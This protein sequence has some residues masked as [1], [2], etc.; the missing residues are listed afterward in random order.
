M[1]KDSGIKSKCVLV[2]GYKEDLIPE[3]DGT[4]SDW[5]Y[6]LKVPIEQYIPETHHYLLRFLEADLKKVNICLDAAVSE[7]NRDKVHEAADLLRKTHPYF[8][9]HEDHVT[10]CISNS[11]ACMVWNDLSIKDPSPVLDMLGVSDMHYHDADIWKG[12]YERGTVDGLWLCQ[13][14]IQRIVSLILK[15]TNPAL[16]KLPY[17]VRVGL[18]AMLNHAVLRDPCSD[19]ACIEE[20]SQFIL[21]VPKSMKYVSARMDFEEGYEEKYYD[22]VDHVV[23]DDSAFP[24]IIKEIAEKAIAADDGTS[25]TAEKEY[26]IDS[27]E[28]LL[29]LEIKLM[30]ESGCRIRKCRR[31]GKDFVVSPVSAEYCDVIDDTYGK[32]CALIEYGEKIRPE[33]DKIYK[34]AYKTQ[35]ARIR[36]GNATKEDVDQ[37][38]R[39]AKSIQRYVYDKTIS[40]E[41]YKMIIMKPASELA[42]IDDVGIRA[43]LNMTLS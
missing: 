3:P 16:S 7:R 36:S 43:A 27:L 6:I 28:D 20:R 5:G 29:E 41:E 13:W 31:C 32:T 18:Y 12:S 25:V 38:R 30:L 1:I 8:S 35:H 34:T 19:A 11:L 14:D 40:L 22:A 17:S 37:W 2:L 9:E 39:D 21:P 26:I 4:I 10:A 42:A 24:D 23:A 15:D 33:V